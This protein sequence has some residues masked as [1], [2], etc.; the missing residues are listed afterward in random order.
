MESTYA[1]IENNF[2]TSVEVVTDEF[3]K[4]NPQRYKGIWRKVGNGSNRPFC[5][6]GYEYLPGKDKIITPKPYTSWIL[7]A[8][9][10]YQAPVKKPIG[11]YYW[12]EI[13]QNWEVIN[14]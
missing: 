14:L 3:F 11:D 7:N 4:A 9:D 5:G 10:E 13:K 1:K 12:D 2:V 6:K 8:N